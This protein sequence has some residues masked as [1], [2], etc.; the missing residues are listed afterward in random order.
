MTTLAGSGTRGS[1]DGVGDAAQF[2]SPVE[3]AISADGST[4][5]VGSRRWPPPGLRGGA[6]S[7][8]LLCP[9]RRSALDPLADLAKTRGDATLPQG[10]VT[11]LVG[12]DEERIEHVSKNALRPVRSFGPCLASA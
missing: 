3:V 7:A 2:D 5:L 4:L 1:A 9:D 12:D 10:M 8:S 11:F 6:S